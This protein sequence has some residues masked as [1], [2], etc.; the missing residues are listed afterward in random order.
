MNGG[1]GRPG[2]DLDLLRRGRCPALRIQVRRWGL[3]LRPQIDA[4]VAVF[5]RALKEGLRIAVQG[6]VESGGR[7]GVAHAGAE[8]A[9]AEPAGGAVELDLGERQAGALGRLDLYEA[10]Y[11]GTRL[12]VRPYGNFEP[13][14]AGPRG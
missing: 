12:R 7:L 3:G 2:A 10:V 11:R 8:T 5:R 1:A 9:A 4:N 14:V 13:T 6:L